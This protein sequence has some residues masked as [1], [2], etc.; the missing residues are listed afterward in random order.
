M[1][2]PAFTTNGTTH[3]RIHM[4]LVITRQPGE[5]FLIGENIEVR[6]LGV[7]SGNKVRILVEA[8]ADVQIMR[9]ELIDKGPTY[10]GPEENC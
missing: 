3:E 9:E 6:V 1:T 10:R 4:G 7:G 8:P 5:M 2:R